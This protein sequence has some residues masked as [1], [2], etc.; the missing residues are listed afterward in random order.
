MV[1]DRMEGKGKEAMGG[2]KEKAGGLTGDHETEA[3]GKADQ[4][5]GKAQGVMGK[6]KDAASDA[7]DKVKDTVDR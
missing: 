7:K 3:H 2:V 6:V 1:Q 5:E 4:T